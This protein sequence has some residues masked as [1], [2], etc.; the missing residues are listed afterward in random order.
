MFKTLFGKKSNFTGGDLIQETIPLSGP[1][2]LSAHP[3]FVAPRKIDSRDMCLSSSN[4][5]QTPHC[6][7]YSTAGYI[8]FNNWKTLHF[9]KQ[10][11]GDAIYA[12]AKK[13][14][15]YTGDGT[16]LTS[17]ANG[18]INLGLIQGKGKHVPPTRIDVKFALH[19]H[20]VCLAGFQITDEWNKTI[21]DGMI[22]DFGN[23]AKGLGGHAVLLCGYDSKGVYI[24]NSWGRGWGS[25]GFCLL[26]WK[27]FDKQLMSG[28]VVID[29]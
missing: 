16:T 6:A 12:A 24:Q 20:G 25:H 13:I 15:G 21:K 1:E 9:P 5:G 28:L 19:E 8:E 11:N 23:R 27:Q 7:G 29:K 2:V 18:A 4:Q 26:R 17:A 3:K 22:V 14:D 10:V